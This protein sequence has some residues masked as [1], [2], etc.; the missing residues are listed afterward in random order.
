YEND[1]PH[2]LGVGRRARPG[3]CADGVPDVD[4]GDD[5]PVG[6]LSAAPAAVLPARSGLPADAGTEL[7]GVE[8][9][10]AGARPRLCGAAGAGAA[11]AAGARRRWC[12]AS[13][14]GHA[15]INSPLPQRGEGSKPAE[16][17]PSCRGCI[18]WP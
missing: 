12:S 8:P 6:A 2:T 1:A 13:A 9:T 14:S 3:P 7:D 17:F 11:A 5:A 16:T 4:V 15:V 10:A 18:D